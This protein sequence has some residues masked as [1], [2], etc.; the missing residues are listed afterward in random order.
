MVVYNIDEN[1]KLCS[2]L[3]NEY[4]F[5]VSLAGLCIGLGLVTTGLD[6]STGFYA[7]LPCGWNRI[8]PF[9]CFSVCLRR[10]WTTT[11]EKLM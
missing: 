11:C 4:L 7:C 3:S 2:I 5:Y 1:L 9:M 8:C 10:S 6:Y